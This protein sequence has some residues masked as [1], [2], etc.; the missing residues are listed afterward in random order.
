MKLSA[1][2]P[3]YPY[4]KEDDKLIRPAHF[5]DIPAILD[6]TRLAFAPVS[7]DKMRQDFFGE[8]LGYKKYIE[9]YHYL[10]IR[11]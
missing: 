3:F 4:I 7:M 11:D 5:N 9:S 10:K 2:K 6:I 8:K 1:E